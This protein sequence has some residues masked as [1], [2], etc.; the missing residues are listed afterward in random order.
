LYIPAIAAQEVGVAEAEAEV[1]V[2][3]D[4]ADTLPGL[5]VLVVED[6]P[7]VR[8]VVRNFLVSLGC[9]VALCADAEEGLQR[10]Q[11]DKDFDL[12]LSDVALGA[13]MRGPELARQARELLPGL[14]ILLM[15]GFSSGLLAQA[16]DSPL[17]WELLPK[18]YSRE[19]LA[20]AMARAMQA[21]RGQQT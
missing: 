14:A 13:G 7:E 17:P 9:S 8:Y 1:E 3:V 15:S 16:A 19:Q 20:R 5:K 4:G 12:L 10:L 2:E 6:E 11:Y 21:V 18:P